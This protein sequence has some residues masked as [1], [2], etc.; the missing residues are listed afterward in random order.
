ML[1]AAALKD[2]LFLVRAPERKTQSERLSPAVLFA[3]P[4]LNSIISQLALS[5]FSRWQHL[6]LPAPT[7]TVQVS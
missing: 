2:D 6:P 1:H 4:L 7:I 3:W 5:V